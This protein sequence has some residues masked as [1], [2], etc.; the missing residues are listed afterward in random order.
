MYDGLPIKV[1]LSDTTVFSADAYS[2]DRAAATAQI[3]V[4]IKILANCFIDL[5][6]HKIACL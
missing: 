5:F 3:T 2:G 4:A 1:Y 6:Y